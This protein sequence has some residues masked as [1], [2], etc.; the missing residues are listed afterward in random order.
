L[1]ER[2][3]YP[4]L[5]EREKASVWCARELYCVRAVRDRDHT[6]A[7]LVARWLSDGV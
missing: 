6:A 1:C 2:E 3:L 5:R 7:W 4:V